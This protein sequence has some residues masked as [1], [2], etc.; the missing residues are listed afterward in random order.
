MTPVAASGA[1]TAVITG[2]SSGIGEA[3]AL[4]LAEEGFDVVLGARRVERLGEV[5][6]KSG[7]RAIQ[8]DVA[9]PGSV[10]RFTTSIDRADVLINN[11]GIAVG[12]EKVGELTEAGLE[13]VWQTNVMGLIRVTQSLLP[14]LE[15]SE[16]AHI[17]NVGPSGDQ[18]FWHQ[19]WPWESGC[20]GN[21]V[22]GPGASGIGRA[23]R[24]GCGRNHRS[25]GG[26]PSR[27]SGR[28]PWACGSCS[29]RTGSSCRRRRGGPGLGAA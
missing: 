9:D 18:P 4:R 13:K 21:R 22:S 10:D 20:R 12:L 25:P 1:R 16:S 29:C 19:R 6:A 23:H 28:A 15:S 8:L 17:V 27:R 3:T 5:A 7:G 11:A 2:A 24:R 26:Q 14:H